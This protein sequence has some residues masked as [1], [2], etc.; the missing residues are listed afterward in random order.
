MHD[1]L[2]TIFI[3]VLAFAALIQTLL[4]FAIY[5]SIRQ[6]TSKMDGLSEDLIRNVE[7]ISGKV[8]E[9]LA[10]IK[11][12]AE[13]L[14]PIREKV[15][16]ATDIIH[17][18]VTELDAFLAE[19]TKTARLEILRVQDTIHSATQKIE[20]TLEL[21]RRGI[22]TPLNEIN[23]VSRAIRVGLDVLFRRRKGP[24]ST[25]PQDEEMF[26]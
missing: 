11:G 9:G 25:S 24:S 21:F 5:R 4:F 18:R 15:A 13:G 17:K 8:E 1:T 6:L 7:V 19:V 22:V 3:G 26:I 2:L 23:A 20:E 14:K 12:I 10:T 16:A